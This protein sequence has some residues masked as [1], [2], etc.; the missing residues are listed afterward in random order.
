M[1]D[2]ARD[3]WACDTWV[4]VTCGWELLVLCAL[5]GRRRLVVADWLVPTAGLFARSWLWRRVNE[6][7]VIRSGDAEHLAKRFGV[8]RTRTRFVRFPAPS[9]ERVTAPSSG[10]RVPEVPYVYSAGWAHRDWETLSRALEQAAVPAV[11]SC[12]SAVPFP[13]NVTVMPQLSPEDG[14]VFLESAHCL[15]L[16]LKDTHLPSGPLVLLD[17]MSRETAVIATNVNG[18]RD[19]VEDGV[20]GV[21]VPPQDPAALARAIDQVM[22]DRGFADEL[23]ARGCQLASQLTAD[24]FWQGVLHSASSDVTCDRRLDEVSP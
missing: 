8:D 18:V 1:I 22:S 10:V 9:Y 5:K 3:G 15:V 16:A 11:V 7:V 6:F 14:R 23:A 4:V 19:Y 13:R 17:A 24:S 12:D 21:L 20:T 2:V